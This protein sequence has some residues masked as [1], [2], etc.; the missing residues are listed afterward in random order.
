LEPL[1]PVGVRET[2]PDQ[3]ELVAGYVTEDVLEAVPDPLHRL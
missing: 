3:R 1:P 2:G